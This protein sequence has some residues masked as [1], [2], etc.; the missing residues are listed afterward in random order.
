M[1]KKNK[2]K[3]FN[4]KTFMVWFFIIIMTFSIGGFFFGND[5]TSSQVE[6]YNNYN[7]YR[8]GNVWM[9]KIN[10]KSFPFTYLPSQVLDIKTEEGIKGKIIGKASIYT[11]FNPND[12]NLASIELARY[13][14]KEDLLKFFNIY[15][16][17]GI[18]NQSN[19]Y[20]LPIITCENVTE[21]Q[22]VIYFKVN[23]E[24]E[25]NANQT[26]AK[27]YSNGNCIILEGTS[28]EFIA[29]KDRLMCSLAGVMQ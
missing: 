18:T 29:L 15:T 4:V 19:I 8:E 14:L 5:T 1:E 17:E 28:T 22:P 26:S 11:T 7:I 9:T 10:G 27:I 21:Y 12:E 13:E 16:Q 24:I 23:N 20:S 3:V 25:I 2:S 6:K